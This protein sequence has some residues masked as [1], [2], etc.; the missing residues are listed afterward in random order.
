MVE[1]GRGSREEDIPVG[2]SRCS[3]ASGVT[4]LHYPGSSAS[5]HNNKMHK[6]RKTWPIDNTFK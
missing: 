6:N 3:L 2:P 4:F 1:G 5:K